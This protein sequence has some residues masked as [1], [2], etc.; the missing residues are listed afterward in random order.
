MVKELNLVQVCLAESLLTPLVITHLTYCWEVQF[1]SNVIFVGI[2]VH[3]PSLQVRC[4]VNFEV[5]PLSAFLYENPIRLQIP[6]EIFCP[7]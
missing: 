4:N 6:R 5:T 1:E 7:N 2:D 3:G